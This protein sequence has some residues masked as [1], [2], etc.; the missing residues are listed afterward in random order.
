[1]DLKISLLSQNLVAPKKD[2]LINI[3]I[4]MRGIQKVNKDRLK[5]MADTFMNNPQAS[6]I[7]T[8]CSLELQ[9]QLEVFRRIHNIV[10]MEKV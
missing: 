8:N 4:D 6:R 3:F 7:I 1:M 2:K 10:F 9:E 5:F